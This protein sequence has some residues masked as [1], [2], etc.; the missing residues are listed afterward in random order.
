MW[1]GAFAAAFVT[2]VCE[3]FPFVMWAKV[4]LMKSLW[5]VAIWAVGIMK[6][7]TTKE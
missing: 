6:L 1:G 2:P 7:M 5:Y 4:G 3:L